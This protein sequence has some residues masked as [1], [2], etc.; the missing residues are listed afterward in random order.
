MLERLYIDNYKLFS[1]FTLRLGQ[2]HLWMGA[3]GGGRSSVA[4]L[5]ESLREVVSGY[6]LAPH[7]GAHTFNRWLKKT[8]QTFEMETRLEGR[9]YLYKLRIEHRSGRDPEAPRVLAESLDM[10]G[11]PLFEFVDGRISLHAPHRKAPVD[12]TFDWHRSGLAF[13]QSRNE[14]ADI[15]RFKNWISSF[16]YF[17]FLPPFP[18]QAEQEVVRPRSDLANFTGWLRHK[19]QDDPGMCASVQKALKDV[20]PGFSTLRIQTLEDGRKALAA[21][22]TGE[23]Q[24]AMFEFGSLSAGQQPLIALYFLLYGIVLPER[25]VIFDEPDNFVALR[26]IQPWLTVLEDRV[27]ETG[28]L[29]ARGW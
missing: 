22:F 8:D 13:V 20:L 6:P 7:F 16:A 18:S 24:S 3:N 12:F 1:N 10:D 28:S 14:T 15:L 23:A 26:E 11:A 5:L 21:E 29:E 2:F 19:L 27:S 4:R 25:L 17:R 9:S